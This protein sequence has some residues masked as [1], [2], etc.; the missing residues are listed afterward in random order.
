M[1]EETK[2]NWLVYEV[3]SSA[4]SKHLFDVKGEFH[5]GERIYGVKH[6]DFYAGLKYDKQGLRDLIRYLGE[7]LDVLAEIG[8]VHADIKS[9][10]ILVDFDGKRV[11]SLK[12]I[13][14]GSAFDFKAPRNITASTPEYLAPEVLRYLEVKNKT[15]IHSLTNQLEP[16]S[17]DIWSLG[18]TLLEMLTGIPIWLS[19][20]CRTVTQTGK[21]QI[22]MGALAVQGRLGAKILQK[23]TQLLKNLPASL[24]KYECYGLNHDPLFMDLL[25]RMLDCDPRTR[26]S[27]A[28]VLEHP[29]LVSGL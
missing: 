18:A 13:D 19:L 5:G 29:F 4:L 10:N 26:I 24:K 17:F 27:P 3:G 7:A 6:K 15:S 9:E 1:V 11:R 8:I 20:K 22:A 21:S 2:D 28:E 12:L 23:Q 14:F 25:G 16:W